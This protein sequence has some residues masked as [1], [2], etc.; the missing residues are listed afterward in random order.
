[1]EAVYLQ[2]WDT[3]PEGEGF[4]APG[5]QILHCTFGSVLTEPDLG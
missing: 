3:V 4:T 2:T 5:R 1:M